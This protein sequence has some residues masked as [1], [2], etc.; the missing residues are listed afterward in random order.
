M[1]KPLIPALLILCCNWGLAQDLYT[2]PV[3]VDS[4]TFVSTRIALNS[5]ATDQY[6]K[7]V[8]KTGNTA[9]PFRYL[10]P[11]DLHNDQKYPLVITLHNSSRIGTDNEAQLEP[12]ARIWIQEDI[13][14]SFHCFVI[15]PQFSRR[16]SNYEINAD[17]L[18]VSTPS[19][20]A[21]ELLALI[22]QFVKE[23]PQIDQDRIYL[24]GYSMGAST[25]QN[26]MSRA[27]RKFAAL[28]SIAAVPDL[29]DLPALKKKPVWL[30]HGEKDTENP[31][32]GT[33]ALFKKLQGNKK[34]VF[35][36]LP[37]LDHNDIVIPFLLTKQIPQ[38]LFEQRK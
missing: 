9:I 8:F 24:V 11:G 33:V 36:S 30:I 5:L 37:N 7:A 32:A 16:S 10:S 17:S 2:N 3:V 19:D 14:K 21:L 15:A 4:T 6:R 25:A 1:K 38:W 12:L 28:V 23:H 31:Y 22:D 20:D 29:S 34:L 13:Y 27:S 35:T 18:L 26:L